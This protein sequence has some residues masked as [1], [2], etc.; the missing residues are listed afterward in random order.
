MGARLVDVNGD[1]LVD[2]VYHRYLCGDGSRRKG[3]YINTGTGWQ[4]DSNYAPPYELAIDCRADSGARLVDING[5]SLVDL[6]YHRYISGSR[7]YGAYLN[8]ADGTS[9]Q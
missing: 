6:V 2:L 1:G 7:I 9:T 4:A 5:D 3:A 8:T